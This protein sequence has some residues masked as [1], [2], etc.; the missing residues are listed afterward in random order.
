MAMDV[1]VL[2]ANENWFPD[3]FQFDILLSG[4]WDWDQKL[5]NKESHL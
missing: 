3:N 2:S 5:L 1:V 4:E